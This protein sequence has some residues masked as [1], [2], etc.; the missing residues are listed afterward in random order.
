MTAKLAPGRPLTIG[1]LTMIT[2][3]V[4]PATYGDETSNNRPFRAIWTLLKGLV[5]KA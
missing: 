5:H 1:A 4:L 2:Q 3:G